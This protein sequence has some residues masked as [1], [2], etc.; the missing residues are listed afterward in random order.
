MTNLDVI[1]K[2]KLIKVLINSKSKHEQKI[3][4]SKEWISQSA[5]NFFTTKEMMLRLKSEHKDSIAYNE[6]EINIIESILKQLS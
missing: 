3:H 6:N 2:Q 5:S 1:Q 4:E